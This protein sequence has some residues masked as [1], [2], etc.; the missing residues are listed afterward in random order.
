VVR[1][2]A[3]NFEAAVWVLMLASVGAYGAM[4]IGVARH[5]EGI[6]KTEVVTL[7]LLIVTGAAVWWLR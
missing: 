3:G 4:L 1:A 6:L 5:L 2:G 7:V